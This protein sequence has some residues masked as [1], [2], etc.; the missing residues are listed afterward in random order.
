[1]SDLER[2]AFLKRETTRKDA[3]NERNANF[4]PKQKGVPRHADL[5]D[6]PHRSHRI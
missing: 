1:M 4:D 6:Q 3:R 5:R 2:N